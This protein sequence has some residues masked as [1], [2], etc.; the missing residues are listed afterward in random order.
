MKEHLSEISEITICYCQIWRFSPHCDFFS[1]LHNAVYFCSEHSLVCRKLLLN[2]LFLFMEE[3]ILL[4]ENIRHS[5]ICKLA[6][7]QITTP[8]MNF[9]DLINNANIK[10]RPARRQKLASA[11]WN[12]F[13]ICAH[14]A[15]CKSAGRACAGG[16]SCYGINSHEAIK[17][18]SVRRPGRY[19][20][21]HPLTS[22]LNSNDWLLC[23][24]G[25][26]RAKSRREW[27]SLFQQPASRESDTESLGW[28]SVS[29]SL[30]CGAQRLKNKENNGVKSK[31]IALSRSLRSPA[32]THTAGRKVKVKERETRF[33]HTFAINGC[34]GAFLLLLCENSQILPHR[35]FRSR[36]SHG[37]QGWLCVRAPIAHTNTGEQDINTAPNRPNNTISRSLTRFWPHH[38]PRERCEFQG[39]V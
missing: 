9:H 28:E 7:L 18:A 17:R 14:H 34:F 8:Q 26:Q 21:S 35:T 36:F 38:P 10:T 15:Q 30:L 3:W 12:N 23:W 27:V 25:G 32:Q 29:K 13:E 4:Y 19:L 22:V 31:T 2:I 24:G 11:S 16:E 37:S 6:Q 20:H 33:D 1:S 39:R 5:L